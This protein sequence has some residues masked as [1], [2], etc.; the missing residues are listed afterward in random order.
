MTSI[1][2]KQSEQVQ[3]TQLLDRLID[4][5]YCRVPM[6]I[7]PGEFSV[8]GDIIDIFPAT[9]TN[10]VRIEL[11][12]DTVD[13]LTSFLPQHQRSFS[14]L[15]DVT[16]PPFK[17]RAIFHALKKEDIKADEQLISSFNENDFIVHELYGIGLYKG[18]V[19]KN[20]GSVQGEYIHI[21]YQNEDK[22]FVP[23]SQLNAIHKYKK[24]DDDTQ[25]S[26]LTGTK[27]KKQI[28]KAKK[29]ASKL[30]EALFIAYKKRNQAKGFA[31]AEDS[32]LQL[33]IENEF[34]HKLTSDQ[35]SA[36]QD[37]K[38]DMESERPMERLLCG[39]VGYG[40]T[41]VLVRAALKAA[42]SAKQVAV[43]APTT[44]LAE[45]HF[46]T[47][48]KRFQNSPY[49]VQCLS[50]FYS[51]KE[52]KTTIK[53]IKEQRCDIVI[54]THRLLSKDIEFN[55]LGLLII[56]EEQ[57]FGVKHKEV[58]KTLKV[59]VDCISVSA[60]PIPRTL[61]QSLTGSKDCSVIQTAPEFRLP[62]LTT[63]HAYDESIVTKA[64]T[65][66]LKR[67]GQVFY[68]FNKVQGI[69]AK[70][71]AIQALVPQCKLAVLHGQMSEAQIRDVL[72]AFLTN[73]F[74]CLL[75]TT[76]IE[77]GIDIP[78]AN[79]IIIDEAEQY[80]LS[81]I[82][83]LRG[84]VGRSAKQA[85]AYIFYS[86]GKALQ[87]KALDRLQAIREYVS[88]GSGKE[89]AMKDLEIRGAGNILGK[90]QHGHVT[91]LGFNLY[92]KLLDD[93]IRE[94][95]GLSKTEQ[96]LELNTEDISIPSNY[97]ADPRQRIACYMR[98]FKCGS[99]E[100]LAQIRSELEDRYGKLDNTMKTVLVTVKDAVM[101]QLQ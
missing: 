64:I 86:K 77:N 99:V 43:L 41:E 91:S 85:Y 49:I 47:F 6:V 44:I 18:L 79:T 76:I 8:R 31:F 84:R 50:R 60:T 14:S 4:F 28:T 69:R 5:N 19:Y 51:E 75:A 81:Q 46:K 93:A 61:Y 101:E 68:V 12:L 59:N 48:K 88:L 98:F 45:Q 95:R 36:I 22:I 39:D 26:A 100:E 20:F 54:G 23:L 92:C 1:Q 96:W 21:V 38:T 57:L 9:G 94:K 89:L 78:N 97:I 33:V 11:D 67:G 34:E 24:Q 40:K 30:A 52:Q 83:Q 72:Q 56:D 10:P 90:E 29:E 82:H 35:D 37:I 63:V 15:N 71:S 58:L 16:I 65:K 62:V 27:W 2:I 87:Q 7:E 80:G 70:A 3:L 55:D 74:D 73:K 17:D 32:E 25:L 42:E 66:E 13:R 53:A